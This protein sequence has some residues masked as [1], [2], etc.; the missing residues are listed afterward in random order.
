MIT[1]LLF[2]S[3]LSC[4]WLN[5]Y[6]QSISFDLRTATRNVRISTH[7]ALVGPVVYPLTQDTVMG[8]IGYRKA[9]DQS[10]MHGWLSFF[11]RLDSHVDAYVSFLL[12][13]LLVDVPRRH[14]HEI[15]LQMWATILKTQE[16]NAKDVYLTRQLARKTQ[17]SARLWT[18]CNTCYS[19]TSPSSTTTKAPYSG[20][21]RSSHRNR[22]GS[23]YARK[24]FCMLGQSSSTRYKNCLYFENRRS[25]TSFRWPPAKSLNG[26]ILWYTASLKL[27]DNV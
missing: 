22:A 17:F 2:L 15:D 8:G 19:K 3:T 10:R 18:N 23:R 26:W 5:E 20:H 14:F 24:G 13:M 7:Y 4:W 11:G 12:E 1:E 16:K 9:L 25:V 21:F 6:I 27:F